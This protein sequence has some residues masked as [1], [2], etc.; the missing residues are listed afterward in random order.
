MKE[1]ARSRSVISM[2]GRTVCQKQLLALRDVLYVVQRIY[3]RRIETAAKLQPMSAFIKP[4][5]AQVPLNFLRP[6]ALNHLGPR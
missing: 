4:L 3:H 2:A 5:P 1:H 6:C